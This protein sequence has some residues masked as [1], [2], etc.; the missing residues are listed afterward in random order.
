MSNQIFDRCQNTKYIDFKN[1]VILLVT[2]ENYQRTFEAT[3][4]INIS[5]NF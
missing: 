2:F 4:N 5:K 3:R 1:I